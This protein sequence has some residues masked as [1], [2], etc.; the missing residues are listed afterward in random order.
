MFKNGGGGGYTYDWGSMQYF[1]AQGEVVPF[2]EV[3]DNYVSPNGYTVKSSIYGGS[4]SNPYEYL[5]GIL[6]TDGT[7]L[8]KNNIQS[9]LNNG[10]TSAKA[11]G[12]NE[13]YAGELTLSLSLWELLSDA[14][15][16]ALITIGKVV[17]PLTLITI[18]GDTRTNVYTENPVMPLPHTAERGMPWTPT[19]SAQSNKNYFN[20]GPGNPDWLKW[21]VWSAGGLAAGK[22][23]Y[24][25][26]PTPEIP[27]S[28]APNTTPTVSPSTPFYTWP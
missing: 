28:P 1:N 16:A 26:W 18:S 27:P 14:G 25:N 3:M 15:K 17:A 8:D 6:L 19:V 20:I 9:F 23:L 10:S 7:Y 4:Q 22:A 12:V 2:S 11:G 24:D 21:I 5:T 13:A